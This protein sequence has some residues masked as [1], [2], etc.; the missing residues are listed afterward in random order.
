MPSTPFPRVLAPVLLAAL[1]L[2]G[3]ASSTPT[4]PGTRV[5][6]LTVV[7]VRHAEKADDGSNDPQLSEAGTRRATALARNGMLRDARAVYASDTRRAQATAQP[8]A[9]AH[10]LLVTTYDARDSAEA[11]AARLR[12]LH[13]SGGTVLVVGHS[14]TVPALAA[15]LCTCTVAPMDETT[16]DRIDTVR[17]DAGGRATHRQSR[18]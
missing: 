3:C 18:Q 7:L 10:G 16:F 9:D 14:N 17:I 2:Q 1:V 4:R 15:A 12:T 8:T 5:A 13:V 11:F 6:P